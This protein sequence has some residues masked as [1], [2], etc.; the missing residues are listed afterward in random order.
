MPSTASGQIEEARSR[1]EFWEVVGLL[2]ADGSIRADKKHGHFEVA[3]AGKDE[4]L[5]QEFKECMR[6][7][8]GDIHLSEKTGK[9]NVKI[10]RIFKRNVVNFFLQFLPEWKRKGNKVLNFPPVSNLPHSCLKSFIR[11]FFSAEGSAVLGC[12]WHKLKKRWIINKRIQAT[13]K[14]ESLKFFV[15][16]VLKELGFSPSVWKNEVVLTKKEDILKFSKDIRF[17]E[18]VKISRKSRVWHGVEKN[19]I[20]DIIAE[21]CKNRINSFHSLDEW[22]KFV[23]LASSKLRAQVSRPGRAAQTG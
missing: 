12:K 13:L 16:E 19:K 10:I 1:E 7:L 22:A 2:L 9:H 6:K 5:I 18:G 20:L 23:D 11:G 17:L 3:F 21:L 8:F 15:A 14:N 4:I